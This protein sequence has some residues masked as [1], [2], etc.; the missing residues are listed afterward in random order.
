MIKTILIDTN[1][2]KCKETK[3]ALFIFRNIIK[4]SFF[5]LYKEHFILSKFIENYIAK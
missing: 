5:M 2:K 1:D 4:I 3:N